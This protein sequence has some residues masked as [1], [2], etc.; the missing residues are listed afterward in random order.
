M[1]LSL[2]FCVD[3]NIVVKHEKEYTYK[4]LYVVKYEEL[5][6]YCALNQD[7]L[8]DSTE[9]FEEIKEVIRKE[10]YDFL[11]NCFNETAQDLI[12]RMKLSGS[13]EFIRKCFE[14]LSDVQKIYLKDKCYMFGESLGDQLEQVNKEIKNI[15]QEINFLSGDLEVFTTDTNFNLAKTQLHECRKQLNL[16]YETK[17]KIK[18]LME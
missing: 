9:R 4:L 18:S 7:K 2:L 8:P 16:L 12:M 1:S 15:L 11:L 13:N 5:L 3:G 17:Y 6:L 10:Y 14:S